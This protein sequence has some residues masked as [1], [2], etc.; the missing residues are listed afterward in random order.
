MVIN[1]F[2]T[3]SLRI[4]YAFSTNVQP[5]AL[6]AHTECNLDNGMPEPYQLGHAN[7]EIAPGLT[8]AD[9]LY[10]ISTNS[11]RILYDWGWASGFDI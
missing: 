10:E 2:S 3:T 6:L 4:L 9:P 11:L 5:F 7:S 8:Q 1:S